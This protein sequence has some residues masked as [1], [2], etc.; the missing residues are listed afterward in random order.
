MLYVPATLSTDG[1]NISTDVVCDLTRLGAWVAF[2]NTRWRLVRLGWVRSPVAPQNGSPLFRLGAGGFITD[3]WTLGLDGGEQQLAVDVLF[4][5]GW[6]GKL[7][8]KPGGSVFLAGTLTEAPWQ[9]AVDVAVW[10]LFEP[11]QWREEGRGV[12]C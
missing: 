12:T 8:W 7:T 9:S 10:A 1:A 4:P 3:T 6:D 11:S 5:S 2:P